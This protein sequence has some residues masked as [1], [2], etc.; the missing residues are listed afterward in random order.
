MTLTGS[1]GHEILMGR[2]IMA[3]LFSHQILTSVSI[4]VSGKSPFIGFSQGD[5]AAG[6]AVL[7]GCSSQ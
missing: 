2:K 5:Y 6:G 4:I 7:Y 1:E 3:Q